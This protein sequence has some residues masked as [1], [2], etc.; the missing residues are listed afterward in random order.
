MR[1]GASTEPRSKESTLPAASMKRREGRDLRSHC[2][3][4][5][6]VT[7]CGRE[8]EEGRKAGRG[9][10]GGRGQHRRRRRW[11]LWAA[12]LGSSLPPSAYYAP[13][14]PVRTT[15]A[16]ARSRLRGRGREERASER[17]DLTA[18]LFPCGSLKFMKNILGEMRW[19]T[20]LES[21]TL[22]HL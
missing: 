5:V 17:G 20:E 21:P 4:S 18:L 3:S 7:S 12:K 14:S 11:Q 1:E 10:E 16:L 2:P 9:G 6:T 19:R 22:Q 13:N 8:P 15:T